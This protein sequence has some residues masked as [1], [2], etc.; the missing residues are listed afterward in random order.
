M[1]NYTRMVLYQ[2]Y[3]PKKF[4]E[5]VNQK[6]VH[7][8]L[9]AT[10]KNDRVAHAYLFAGPRGTGKTTV[11][12]ILARA[13][14]CQKLKD[15]EPC[16]RCLHCRES[17]KDNF[18]DL[19]ETDAAS[20]R[21]IDQIRDL[22]E[23][24]KFSPIV[25]DYKVYIIDEVHMMTKEAFNALLKILEEPPSYAIFIL[26]TTEPHKVP[27]T[28]LSR[29]QR[30][31]FKLISIQDI[32]KHLK[33]IAKLEKFKIDDQAILMIAAA[34]Q[35]SMRD[36]LG[37]LEQI[38]S[39]APSQ[40][41]TKEVQKILGL[42]EDRAIV[43]LIDQLIDNQPEQAL[44]LVNNL[45]KQGIRPERIIDSINEHLRRLLLAKFGLRWSDLQLAK[46]EKKKA[47][48][49]AQVLT[50]GQ[51]NHWIEIFL[52]VRGKLTTN[53]P[54]LPLEMAIIKI[55]G[56][57]PTKQPKAAVPSPE[58]NHSQASKVSGQIS[59]KIRKSWPQILEK[60]KGENHSLSGIIAH[61]QLVMTKGKRLV[62]VTDR[63]FYQ[64]KIMELANRRKIERTIAS[65]L[66]Q[67]YQISCKLKKVV[68]SVN[69]KGR[70]RL[71]KLTEKA[72]K[73][74]GES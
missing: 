1:S 5:L 26:A 50:I 30:F 71:E 38:A 43:K 55:A 14:N 18:I 58:K 47:V 11:A 60:L 8:T 46:E 61:C 66:G 19:I 69:N 45:I 28:V 4:K 51:I 57:E 48:G 34:G 17:Q 56:N 65:C 49:Q 52:E 3:R 53:L 70:D 24:I 9:L 59:G 44:G 25:A 35:G 33:K 41:T 37:I 20:N 13:M 68:K 32:A 22:K 67:K 40:V 54:Q 2:K 31:D 15:G 73:V 12:R 62:L 16:G 42:V 10:L 39:A 7:D 21:G 6:A 74:F 27:E 64:K 23:K 29:C 36:S 72:Q 63:S